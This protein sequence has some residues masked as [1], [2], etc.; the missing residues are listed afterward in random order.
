MKNKTSN[1]DCEEMIKENMT[2]EEVLNDYKNLMNSNLD[3]Y[4]KDDLIE[5]NRYWKEWNSKGYISD[6]MYDEINARIQKSATKFSFPEWIVIIGSTLIALTM[7]IAIGWFFI[8]FIGTFIG[9]II[10][11]VALALVFK[12]F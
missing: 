4:T 10:L 7:I 12:M 3:T 1:A 9:V 2:R 6:E 11:F 5:L 8:D